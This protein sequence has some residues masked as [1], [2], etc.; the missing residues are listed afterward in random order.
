MKNKSN[1]VINLNTNSKYFVSLISAYLNGN[2]PEAQSDFDWKEIYRL[3]K[4]HNVT[5]IIAYE[6]GLL[7]EKFRPEKEIYSIFRQQLGYTVINYEEK[8]KA[9]K[10][11][12]DFLDKNN[13]DY[14][15]IKGAILC[16]YYPVKE[17]RTSG[18]ID[19]IVR[20]RDFDKLKNAVSKAEDS[21]KFQRLKTGDKNEISLICNNIHIEIHNNN[22]LDN[23]YFK[24][25]FDI[26]DN[27]G[28]EYFIS[29]KL[30][31]V[32]VICH[33]AKHFNYYGAGIR[34]F[35]DI[36]IL[37][38]RLDEDAFL[39]ALKICQELGLD[40]FARTCMSICKYWFDTPINT[41]Y[42]IH[43]NSEIKEIF[44]NEVL[45]FGTFGKSGKSLTDFYLIAGTSNSANKKAYKLKGIINF[46]FPDI[47]YLKLRYSFLEKHEYLLPAAWALRIGEGITKRNKH[48]RETLNSIVNSSKASDDYIRLLKELDI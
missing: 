24:N 44:E 27:S 33:I 3:S 40:I 32:Y 30:H 6:A 17:F 35:M 7:Q 45:N 1:E 23:D 26:S 18:D 19:V 37:A 36:D 8:L 42:D 31:L 15:F 29:D 11:I 22:G 47:K 41:Q 4:I 28:N 38:R 14:M 25:I 20:Q 12:S 9:K 39:S 43:K 34:M 48:S 21:Q 16:N 10:Y 2:T 46:V 5:A 13:I